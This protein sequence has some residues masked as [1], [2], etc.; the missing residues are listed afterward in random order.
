[1]QHQPVGAIQYLQAFHY[2]QSPKNFTAVDHTVTALLQPVVYRYL[3]NQSS[4]L[5]HNNNQQKRH[6]NT[7]KS[8]ED[9]PKPI[10]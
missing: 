5:L 4:K 1:M 9:F 2:N 3:C 7:G 10:I 8:S 6:Y